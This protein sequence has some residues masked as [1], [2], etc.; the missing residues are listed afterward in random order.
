MFLPIQARLKAQ[1]D[2]EN[3][4]RLEAKGTKIEKKELIPASVVM[5]LMNRG[6]GTTSVPKESVTTVSWI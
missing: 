6:V 1:L 5:V 4:T 3:T 2:I